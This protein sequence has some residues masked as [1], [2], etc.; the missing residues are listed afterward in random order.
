LQ[1]CAYI[2]AVH[3]DICDLLCARQASQEMKSLVK[4]HKRPLLLIV[5]LIALLPL[6]RY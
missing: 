3:T 2:Q 6:K 5:L 4:S 1:S